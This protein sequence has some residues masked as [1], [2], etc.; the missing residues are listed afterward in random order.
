[1]RAASFSLPPS[2][3]PFAPPSLSP[4]VIIVAAAGGQH[5]AVRT[6]VRTFILRASYAYVCA[7]ARGVC[8]CMCG[9]RACAYMCVNVCV[10]VY[11]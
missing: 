7:C 3:L 6:C 11:M 2:F 4:P 1:M 9:A 8:V 5:D 10:Y